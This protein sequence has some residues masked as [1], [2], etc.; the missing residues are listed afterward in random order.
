MKRFLLVLALSVASCRGVV[1]EDRL[2]CP[3]FLFFEV[4]NP[5][6]FQ[7]YEKVYTTVCSHPSGGLIS[8]ESPSLGSI[9]GKAFYVEVRSTEA[10]K[11]YGILGGGKNIEYRGD[12]WLIPIGCQSDSIYRFSYVANVE[13]DSF[14]VPVEFIKEHAKVSLQFVGM[15]S[16]LDRDGR[17][18][19]DI[20]VRSNTCGI[21]AQS[22]LPV[23]G[24][25]EYRPQETTLGH[26]EFTLPRQGD[27]CLILELYG[28]EH[29]YEQEGFIG[30]FNLYEILLKQGGITWREK[31]LP[32]VSMEL[33]Y[34][35][36]RVQV[37]V[38]NWEKEELGFE[39]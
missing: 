35:E 31:S 12:Q 22:G 25:F 10:V 30:S 36:T 28:R 39:I 16:Y 17:F 38:D 18:P 2:E 13:P 9:V 24:S 23:R 15:E 27:N 19:F 5:E 33:D 20:V 7:L 32:D 26:F 29:I 37:Q 34:Q 11:G 6:H 21:D 8:S 4:S 3:S 1:L 14:T